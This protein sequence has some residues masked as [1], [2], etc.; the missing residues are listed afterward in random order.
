LSEY[1]GR[2]KT[3]NDLISR[4]GSGKKGAIDH[5]PLRPL[6]KVPVA[7]SVGEK[8]SVVATR[9]LSSQSPARVNLQALDPVQLPIAPTIVNANAAPTSLFS[10]CKEFT[11]SE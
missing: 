1:P 8:I 6:A 2:R 4:R 5:P 9:G 11:L 10:W 7:K 3:E